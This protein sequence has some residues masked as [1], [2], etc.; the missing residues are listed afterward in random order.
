MKPL[1]VYW[2]RAPMLD[3]QI[4]YVGCGDNPEARRK[5]A[6]RRYHMQLTMVHSE[7]YTDYTEAGAHETLEIGKHW[8]TVFNIVRKSAISVKFAERSVKIRVSL[9]GIVRSSETRA[10]ISA[11]RTGQSNGPHSMEARKKIGDGNRGKVVTEATR[12]LIRRATTGKK[13]I[14]RA[15][16]ET[17]G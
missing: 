14:G 5:A 11:F 4:V 12:E 9:T 10:K 3:N 6:Q 17:H 1:Y 16:C 7:A 8:S 13:T 2:L 15:Y